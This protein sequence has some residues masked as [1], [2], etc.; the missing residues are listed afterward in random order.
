MDSFDPHKDGAGWLDDLVWAGAGAEILWTALE[1]GL[2]DR[3]RNGPVEDD[4]LARELGWDP[5]AGVRFL[6]ALHAL[7]LVALHEGS[8]ANTEP[9]QRFLCSDG[10]ESLVPALLW[11]RELASGWKDLPRALAHGGRSAPRAD[12]RDLDKRRER[13]ARAMAAVARVK[14]PR[15]L[16]LFSGAAPAGRI[17]D[18]GAGAGTV[19]AAFLETFPRLTGEL[20]DLSFMEPFVRETMAARSL[21]PRV[22]FR[23]ADV[24]KDWPVE[25][26][27]FSIVLLSNIVH[28]F[29]EIELPH[30]MR[31]A[32]RAAA[33][34]GVV[35][36]HDYF[37]EHHPVKASFA[38]LLMLMTTYNGRVIPRDRIL[39]EAEAAGL[40][41]S[42]F[43]PFEGDTAVLA[44]SR[45]PEGIG[46]LTVRPEDR[47]RSEVLALGFTRAV[48]VDPSDVAVADWT[49]GKCLY[50]CD[51]AGT[52]TCPPNGPTAEET[53]RV[54]GGFRRALLLEGEPPTES[55][56]RTVLRAESLA[57]RRGFYRA[58]S[59]WSVVGPLSVNLPGLLTWPKT[60]T[61]RGARWTR[62]GVVSTPGIVSA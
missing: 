10:D 46:R 7:G 60:N 9:A 50:G 59:Y 19:T 34:D 42:V 54:L 29:S 51:R 1:T 11:R 45:S 52:G 48:F 22:V 12:A 18:V 26:D 41:E 6:R 13:Y 39:R 25:N 27:A 62:I 5:G 16:E 55:F 40:S 57:F 4:T 24:L 38:D 14:A 15:L 21:S 36:V 17:L 32:A 23:P 43:V 37:P 31:E 30:L 61:N 28:A 33:S 47:V 8:V 58:R 3:L 35:L 56:Q 53:G 2:F 44:L 49:R 20:L